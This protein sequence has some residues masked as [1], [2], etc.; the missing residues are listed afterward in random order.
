MIKELPKPG[1][2]RVRFNYNLYKNFK[3]EIQVLYYSRSWDAYWCYDIVS[4]IRS[5]LYRAYA[6]RDNYKVV[7]W[8]ELYMY[9]PDY[10]LELFEDLEVI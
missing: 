3:L 9:V 1:Y 4:L 6:N 10:F 5:E 2:A 8:N 7:K